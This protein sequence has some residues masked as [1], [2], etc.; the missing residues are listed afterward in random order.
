MGIGSLD[1]V[2]GEAFDKVDCERLELVET[3]PCLAKQKGKTHNIL[4]FRLRG[5]PQIM[6]ASAP[7]T[8]NKVREAIERAGDKKG[9]SV[10]AIKNYIVATWPESDNAQLKNHLKKA[11][12]KGFQLEMFK[13]PKNSE[14]IGPSLQGR[15]MINKDFVAA[16]DKAK[17]A[18]EKAAEKKSAAAEKKKEKKDKSPTRSSS[19]SPP[20][21]KKAKSPAR[22]SSQS[23]PKK[24][25][26]KSKPKKAAEKAKPIKSK[27]K[28][29]KKAPK[30]VAA[31]KKILQSKGG[32]STPKKTAKSAPKSKK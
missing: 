23:P 7:N 13:R 3:F 30:A 8:L 25:V 22:S 28:S 10:V 19:Q 24:A 4:Q 17:K 9:T 6:A 12:E 27:A 5:S 32:V 1:R 18:K 16:E 11:I 2:S 26:A 21:K 20:K 14:V 31:K 15:I 29:P